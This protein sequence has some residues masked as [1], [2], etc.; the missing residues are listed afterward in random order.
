MKGFDSQVNL[1]ITEIKFNGFSFL[2]STSILPSF[3][4]PSLPSF[5]HVDVLCES[6]KKVYSLEHS[7]DVFDHGACIG[8]LLL[9]DKAL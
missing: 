6:T 1:C 8:Y 5:P 9:C 2:R 7:P 4:P 3:L